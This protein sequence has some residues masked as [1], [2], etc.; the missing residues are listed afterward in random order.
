MG[1]L[2]AQAPLNE[3]GPGQ[4]VRAVRDSLLSLTPQS[5]AAP[6]PLDDAD[7]ANCCIAGLWLRFNYLT[8]SH[9]LSQ[10]IDTPDGSYWH[11]LMHRREP[12][13]ANAKYWVRRIGQHPIYPPLADAARGL[14]GE[15]QADEGQADVKAAFLLQLER[16]DPL[17]FVDLCS[18]AAEGS[19]PLG[20]LCRRIQQREWE[21]LF[22]HCH[23]DCYGPRSRSVVE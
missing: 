11:A 17:R 18:A 9:R 5:V 2:L 7:M 14:A 1:P 8:E 6:Q 13:F 3:L 21:L 12:D 19:P 20:Q 22:D 23:R 16:W 10:A 15:G 4:P